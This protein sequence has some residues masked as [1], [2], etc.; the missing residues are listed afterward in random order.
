MWDRIRERWNLLFEATKRP[1]PKGLVILFASIGAYDTFLAQFLP[2]QTA[3]SVPN[4]FEI[5]RDFGV[6]V[7]G[8]PWWVWVF[9][10][11]TTVLLSTLEF[12]VR[13]TRKYQ[14]SEAA[15]KALV[16]GGGNSGRRDFTVEELGSFMSLVAPD[17]LTKFTDKTFVRLLLDGGLYAF[18]ES[19]NVDSITDNGTGDL[20][21]T[22]AS[23][24]SDNYFVKVTTDGSATWEIVERTP[25]SCRITFNGVDP[26]RIF[27]EFEDG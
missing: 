5:L 10:L 25:S 2:K 11:F 18:L 14:V 7:A 16:S 8:W 26:S 24:L 1:W 23:D 13:Q 12:A 15:R 22:F 4:I 3:E 20:T 19:S 27:L 6:W 9:G 21:V 17:D